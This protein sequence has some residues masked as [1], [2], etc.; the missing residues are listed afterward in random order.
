MRLAR[1]WYAAVVLVCATACAS[2]PAGPTPAPGPV[3]VEGLAPG[4]LLRVGQG[5]EYVT[6]FLASV[7]GD[8]IRLQ[9]DGRLHARARAR[10]DTVWIKG[11]RTHNTARTGLVLGLVVG[12]IV[13]IAM[14]QDAE[15]RGFATTGGLGVAGVLVA[16]GLLGDAAQ[17]AP[18]LQVDPPP[19][20]PPSSP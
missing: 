20:T 18:W 19:A 15:T 2:P 10:A 3:T 11:R 14:R 17:D 1:R 12:G 16:I 4:T 5:G 8:T 6:G 9:R 7:D 13:F